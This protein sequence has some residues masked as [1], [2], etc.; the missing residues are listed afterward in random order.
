MD[1]AALPEQVLKIEGDG[2]SRVGNGHRQAECRHHL[3][4]GRTAREIRREAYRAHSL[5]QGVADA[6]DRRSIHIGRHEIFPLL[7]FAGG[8]CWPV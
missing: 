8:S 1:H 5:I 3:G 7:L 4:R 6:H 2:D